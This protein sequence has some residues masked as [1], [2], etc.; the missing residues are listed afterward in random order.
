M[1]YYLDYEHLFIHYLMLSDGVRTGAFKDAIFEC[2]KPGDAVLDVGAGLGILSFFASR[3]GAKKVVAVERTRI[4]DLAKKIAD[5]NG[6][7]AIE[8]INADVNEFRSQDKFDVVV[9]ECIGPF[10]L[11]ENMISDALK[12]RARFL[13]P[14]GKMIPRKIDMFLVP[15]E[16]GIAYED[17]SFWGN[18][19]GF[20]FTPVRHICEQTSFTRR[21]IEANL[22]STPVLVKTI[23]LQEDDS[24]SLDGSFH[25]TVSRQGMFHGMCGY[26]EARLSDNVVLS[27]APGARETHWEQQLF[28]A[29]EPVSVQPGDAIDVQFSV[30]FHPNVV[31]WNWSIKVKGKE[32]AH[33]TRNGIRLL[34]DQGYF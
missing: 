10:V 14:G 18:L 11:Q 16:S 15:V 31:D 13:K 12:A 30:D 3:A 4:V 34:H 5:G 20:D 6:L 17:V 27:N 2:V 28:P 8:F 23:D 9:S 32:E 26:F 33:S 1:G 29:S 22:L 7:D 21:I 19:Y 25:F 24:I